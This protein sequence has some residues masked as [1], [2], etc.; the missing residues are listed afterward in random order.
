MTVD[1]RW[2]QQCRAAVRV[3][4]ESKV[5]VVFGAFVAQLARRQATSLVEVSL[6]LS[7]RGQDESHERRRGLQRAR[8]VFGM[9]LGGDVVWM[10]LQFHDLHSLLLG[11]VSDEL[12]ALSLQISDVFRI[13]FI[14]MAVALVDRIAV[15]VQFTDDAVALEY[16]RS[17]AQSH[18]SAHLTLRV[19]LRHVDDQ[20][21]L[22]FGIDFRR[23]SVCNIQDV[24]S[25]LNH[26]RL[27]A[28]ADAEERFLVLASPL[29]SSDLAFNASVTK[30]A[31][32]E[33]AIALAQRLPSLMIRNGILVL[34]FSFQVGRIDELEIQLV[35]GLN[36]RVLQRLRHRRVGILQA[37][38]LS[39]QGNVD[40]AREIVDATSEISKIIKICY[41]NSIC[42]KLFTSIGRA[43]CR[44]LSVE[45]SAANVPLRI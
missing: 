36:R 17:P 41:L 3:I 30:P 5:F 27:Q 8:Q 11:I 43:T 45:E 33:H 6:K 23:V 10:T 25:E 32:N 9:I 13:D 18:C 4:Q 7:D 16:R 19:V 38:V 1:L 20:R 31:W 15:S 35:A 2:R 44:A 22:R 21:V 24:S 28:P 29:T 40:F 14:A 42:F 34:R 37:S 12:Q 39:D 26:G